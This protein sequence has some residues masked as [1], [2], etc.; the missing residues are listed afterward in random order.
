MHG[1]T[2][3]TI[4][5]S[6]LSRPTN[7]QYI[8]RKY[9][10]TLHCICI[11]FRQ[12]SS[13][14]TSIQQTPTQNSPHCTNSHQTTTGTFYWHAV[15]CIIQQW[16]SEHLTLLLLLRLMLRLPN[17]DADALKHVGVIT[18][19][20]ILLIYVVHL[21]VWIINCTEWTART[22]KLFLWV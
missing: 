19:Y 3:K 17:D 18:I 20:K 9:C 7:A 16:S 12:F 1:A 4:F 2:I 11:I 13:H 15:D 21:L 5:I 6:L 14:L 22:S 10:Y 8:Y